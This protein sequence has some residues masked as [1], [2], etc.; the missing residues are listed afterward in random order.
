M[1]AVG[2]SY[3]PLKAARGPNQVQSKW[4]DLEKAGCS[5]SALSGKLREIY[6]QKPEGVFVNEEICAEYGHFC[7]TIQKECT[8]GSLEESTVMTTADSKTVANDTSEQ[9]TLRV[10]L[11]STQTRGISVTVTKASE[12][13]FTNEIPLQLVNPGPTNLLS[14]QPLTVENKT[15]YTKSLLD[16]VKV[17]E[18]VDVTLS[19]GQRVEVVLCVSWAEV[20]GEFF[21]PFAI[22][23]WCMSSY[24]EMV[25]GQGVWL[26]ELSS[27]FDLPQSVL[28]GR[29]ECK[30]DIKRSFDIRPL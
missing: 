3:V 19:P 18:S 17:S 22:E 16:E 20:K 8:Y 4:S 13:S 29:F 7:Y 9:Q 15:G 14:S 24:S 30:Y 2:R 27:L 28:R 6:S 10:E 21:V 1:A 5:R 11:E 23:G 12:F 25:N 26:H